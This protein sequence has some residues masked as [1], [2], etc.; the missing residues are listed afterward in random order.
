M[1]HLVELRQSMHL[2]SSKE[3][4]QT[5]VL[6]FYLGRLLLKIKDTKTL[7]NLLI[8]PFYLMRARRSQ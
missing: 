7:F 3:R 5:T 1:Q 8:L 4:L 6:Q 2:P